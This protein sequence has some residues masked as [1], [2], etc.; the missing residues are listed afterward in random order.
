MFDKDIYT[1]GSVPEKVYYV[2][3]FFKNGEKM[4]GKKG[5]EK[6]VN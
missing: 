2:Q 3:V 6:R 5:E 1:F 4:E